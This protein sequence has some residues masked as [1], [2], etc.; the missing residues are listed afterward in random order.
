MATQFK[1]Y[2]SIFG[3]QKTQASGKALSKKEAI[4]RSVKKSLRE[5]ELSD[6]DVD[7]VVGQIEEVITDV[8]NNHG[9]DNS[10][11]DALS[12]TVKDINAQNSIINDIQVMERVL[13]KKYTSIFKEADKDEPFGGKQAPP[14]DAEDAEEAREKKAKKEHMNR[15]SRR[16]REEEAEAEA[17]DDEEEK[18]K[19]SESNR[20][21]KNKI[22]EYA[23]A[24]KK[25]SFIEEED[26]TE[27]DEEKDKKA[28]AMRRKS[29]FIREEEAEDDEEEMDEAVYGF[30]P[31]YK[32]ESETDEGDLIDY[33]SGSDY[34]ALS[35]IDSEGNFSSDRSMEPEEDDNSSEDM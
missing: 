32:E 13:S 4:I 9:V 34:D 14:F 24:L 6:K 17:E 28:E 35:S 12:N 18:E 3:E 15:L 10:V 16:L 21:R 31:R 2:R 27:E 7:S 23:R 19:T 22:K 11:V 8:I 25:R 29:R 33:N 26:E 20:R 5:Q 1:R 30:K